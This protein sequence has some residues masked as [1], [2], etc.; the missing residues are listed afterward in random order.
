MTIKTYPTSRSLMLALNCYT[1]TK[2]HTHKHTN[3]HARTLGGKKQE[4]ISAGAHNR[5]HL[6]RLQQS[7]VRSYHNTRVSLFL[8]AKP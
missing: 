6:S 7:A 2:A 5:L 3:T 1:H 8:P 4:Q